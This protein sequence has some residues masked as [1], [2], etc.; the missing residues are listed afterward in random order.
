MASFLS[1]V[2]GLK[3]PQRLRGGGVRAQHVRSPQLRPPLASSVLNH[4][5]PQCGHARLR[6]ERLVKAVPEP[7]AAQL[8]PSTRVERT[9]ERRHHEGALVRVEAQ[10]PA[11]ERSANAKFDVPERLEAGREIVGCPCCALGCDG[12]AV[13]RDGQAQGLPA[14]VF[15]AAARLVDDDVVGEAVEEQVL[16]DWSDGIHV[17]VIPIDEEREDT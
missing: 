17:R 3:P 9:P 4:P 14:Q 13:V 12:C 16:T 5:R 1:L 2:L 10:R 6:A 11:G 7:E 15:D 8:V